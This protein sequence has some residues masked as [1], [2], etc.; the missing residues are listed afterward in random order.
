MFMAGASIAQD[1]PKNKNPIVVNA[2]TLPAI[3]WRAIETGELQRAV[4]RR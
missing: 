1:L 2:T 4:D 3:E